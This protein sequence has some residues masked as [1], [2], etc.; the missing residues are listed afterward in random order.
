MDGF[1]NSRDVSLRWDLG[2]VNDVCVNCEG[3]GVCGFDLGMSQSFCKKSKNHG[4]FSFFFL[5]FLV[6]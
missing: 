5:I 6:P 3:G 1:K 4:N 2:E